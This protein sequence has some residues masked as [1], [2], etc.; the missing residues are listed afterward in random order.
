ME[1]NNNFF[2]LNNFLKTKS[3]GLS[4]FTKAQIYKVTINNLSSL[5][6]KARIEGKINTNYENI[7][8]GSYCSF[9]LEKGKSILEIIREDNFMIFSKKFHVSSGYSY[10]YNQSF[11]FVQDNNGKVVDEVNNTINDLIVMQSR[12]NSQLVSSSKNRNFDTFKCLNGKLFN[13]GLI[14]F[15]YIIS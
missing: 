11:N 8:N 6:I 15:F 12:G 7:Y 4:E 14:I 3:N 10:T 13:F 2:L 1:N 9:N 5:N